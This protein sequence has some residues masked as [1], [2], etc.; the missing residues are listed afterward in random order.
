MTE[1]Y[2]FA[3]V[4]GFSGKMASGK[5]YTSG[6]LAEKFKEKGL[7]VFSYSFAHALRDEIVE[8]AKDLLSEQ[9]LLSLVKKHNVSLEQLSNFKELMR[10]D[11]EFMNT[12]N[13]WNRTKELRALMQYWGTDVRRASNPDYWVN[14]VEDKI[15][16]EIDNYDVFMI[17]DVR[18]ENEAGLIHR[19]GG[20]LFRCNVAEEIREERL[21][22]RGVVATSEQANH[23]S[24]TSL[25]NYE[26]FDLV[27]NTT[28]EKVVEELYDSMIAKI[29][30]IESVE[31][32]KKYSKGTKRG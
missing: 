6:L 7:Q 11:Q 17:T 13:P 21:L 28:E 22:E 30:Y 23:A 20:T 10:A 27:V 14:K 9:S 8:I 4:I 16:S 19:L 26:K 2:S 12:L 31:G 24:E 1:L 18:F 15:V 32:F 5:D 3:L 25:D 29:D